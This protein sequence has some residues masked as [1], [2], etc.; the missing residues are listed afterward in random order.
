MLR[1]ETFELIDS[2][3]DPSDFWQPRH[4]VIYEAMSE[5]ILG[6]GTVDPVVLGEHLIR[7][8]KMKEAGGIMYVGDLSSDVATTV[9]AGAYASIVRQRA[10]ERE[11]F[12]RAMSLAQS[13]KTKDQAVISS[14]VDALVASAD[15]LSR[16]KMP[17]SLLDMGDSVMEMYS[18]AVFG[19]SGVSLPW[20][21]LNEMTMGMWPG[22]VTFFVARPGTGKTF[23]AVIIARHA[24]L[25]NHP[26]LFISPEMSKAEIAE[27][28]FVVDSGVNYDNVMRGTLSAWEKPKLT[29]A[30]KTRRGSSGLWIMD[31]E[32]DLSPKGIEA[33]VRACKP[34]LLVI[35]SIYDLQIRG[36]RR[37]RALIALEW[38]RNTSKK[39]A[40][41]VCGFAQQ[42]RD[43]ELSSKK[44]GGS[45][46]GTI[47]LAD[48]IG[49]DAHSVFALEQDK[50]MKSDKKLRF[51][52]LKLRRG[53]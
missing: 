51:K 41:P 24:W 4:K 21:T 20:P 10:A 31:S 30:I 9:N 5:I 39:F 18:K 52:P 7:R 47:A 6:G 46:L 36:E 35:D 27:R 28:F 40:M 29:D 37:D 19:L 13:A 12:K 43:A 32:D 23:V 2:I 44:G 25:E 17:K 11:I 38:M 33:A 8:E 53:R 14:G 16:D 34:D 50:D 45:R 3:I 48:E 1:Q 15:R 26:T 42:N 22:T 49:Q